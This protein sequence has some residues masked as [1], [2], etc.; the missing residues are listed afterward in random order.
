MIRIDV[1][2]FLYFFLHLTIQ[3]MQKAAAFLLRL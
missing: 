1:N 2:S 3:G